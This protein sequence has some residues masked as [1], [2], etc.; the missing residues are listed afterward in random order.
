MKK[1]TS[2][3]MSGMLA[4][5]SCV[6]AV[7]ASAEE[8]ETARILVADGINATAFT[9]YEVPVGTKFECVVKG[10]STEKITGFH[11]S[12]YV[13]QAVP[14]A[15]VEESALVEE[16]SLDVLG[17]AEG[18]FSNGVHYDPGMFA[19]MYV[20]PVSPAEF[21]LDRLGFVFTSGLP[22]AGFDEG[23]EMIK[24]AYEVKNPGE[25]MIVTTI[26]D[27]TY[28]DE[29]GIPTKDK[30]CIKTS[31]R[32]NVE[33]Y[34]EDPTEPT[35]PT[36]PSDPTEPTAPTEP[37][38]PTEPSEPTDPSAPTEPTDVTNPTSAPTADDTKAPTNATNATSATTNSTTSNTTSSSTTTGKVAT[39]DTATI[40]MIM[41][42]ILLASAGTVVIA[43]KRLAK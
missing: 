17:Y 41:A 18:Y 36:E 43:R 14:E 13:N 5:T 27:A 26:D 40:A 28:D 38:E 23:V 9:V 11:G 7:T 39:G 30:K 25:C 24:V 34:T 21:N 20:R 32:L 33:E 22:A 15:H 37:T 29:N 12:L 19:S 8:V 3:L 10:T 42:A 4:V 2:L 35:E 31:T 6:C 1:L 16:S